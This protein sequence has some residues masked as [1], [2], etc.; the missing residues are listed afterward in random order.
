AV[1]GTSEEDFDV[2]TTYHPNGGGQFNAKLRVVRKTDGRLL[3]P[4]EGAPLIGPY[5]TGQL[6]IEA[7]LAFAHKLILADI[8]EPE[9]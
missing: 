8:V 7:A 3:F 2:Y 9:G 1:P 4:F 5:P 6:A